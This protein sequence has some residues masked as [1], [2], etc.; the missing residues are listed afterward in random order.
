MRYICV[1]LL[2][3]VVS[4]SSHAEEVMIVAHRGASREAPENT[5]PAFKLAWEQG[6]DAIEGDFRLTGD[7]HVVC[8]HDGNT[9]KVANRDLVVKQSTLEDLQELDVGAYRGK[10]YAGT[11]IPTIAEV[12]ATVPGGKKIYIEIKTDES[13]I[14]ILLKEIQESGLKRE[15]VVVISFNKKVIHDLKVKAPQ[16]KAMW[17][18]GFKKDRSG[19]ITPS[20]EEVLRILK[21]IKADGFSSSKDSISQ[22]FIR[23]ILE[24][25][26]EYHV[27]T[28]DD[29]ETARRFRRWGARSITTN[30]PGYIRKVLGE[31]DGSTNTDKPRD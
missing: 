5:I 14:P 16:F 30:V 1:T 26:F 28:V 22:S 6:A 8:I 4:I 10:D 21:E 18:S 11:I 29:P 17:L 31:T 15:Q 7:G 13:I 9:K 20:L 24:Q 25:G 23:G 12:L 27:W 19:R 2:V 3:L